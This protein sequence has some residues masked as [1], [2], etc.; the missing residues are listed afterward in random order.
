AAAELD[1]QLPL[2]ITYS[3]LRT[4]VIQLGVPST[5]RKIVDDANACVAASPDELKPLMQELVAAFIDRIAQSTEI[6]ASEQYS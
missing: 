4:L 3:T 5:L 1:G 2:Q 6:L